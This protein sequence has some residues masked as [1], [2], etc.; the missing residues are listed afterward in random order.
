MRLPDPTKKEKF[1]EW[2]DQL[3]ANYLRRAGFYLGLNIGFQILALICITSVP[4]S[5]LL[6]ENNKLLA[7]LLS[8]LATIFAA[9]TRFGG[10]GT[11]SKLLYRA[12][13]KLFR[14]TKRYELAIGD[15]QQLTEDEAFAKFVEEILAIREEASVGVTSNRV[16]SDSLISSLGVQPH[17]DQE[18]EP[19]SSSGTTQQG[20]T[21]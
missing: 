6:A 7:A 1:L 15:Y 20:G 4:I 9:L 19:E 10:L 18:K 12:R 11:Q 16:Y 2:T 5:L 17:P 13:W 8:A 3:T 21:R 14:E